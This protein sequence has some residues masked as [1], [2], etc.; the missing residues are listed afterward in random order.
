MPETLSYAKM[1][2]TIVQRESDAAEYLTAWADRTDDPELEKVL[3]IIALR[4]G[5][6]AF[7]FEKRLCELGQEIGDRGHYRDFRDRME[8]MSSDAGDLEKLACLGYRPGECP[9]D[10][11]GKLIED[12]TIDIRTSELLGRYIGEERDS[13]RMLVQCTDEMGRR[14]GNGATSRGSQATLDALCAEIGEIKACLAELQ[15][16]VSAL[17]GLSR[18]KAGRQAEAQH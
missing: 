9:P 15:D 14:A 2:R 4:E 8:M 3:R 10:P 7:A 11:F 17:A 16:S 6:H 1:L 12:P 13:T 18:K 5:E